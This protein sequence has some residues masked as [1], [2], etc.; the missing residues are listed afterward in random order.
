MSVYTNSIVMFIPNYTHFPNS[1]NQGFFVKEKNMSS[2]EN[3][4]FPC[5]SSNEELEP[6]PNELDLLYQK[7]NS[8]ELIEIGWKCPG[9]HLPSPAPV[10]DTEVK[11]NV[12]AELYARYL[13]YLT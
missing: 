12:N 7:L 2:T 1:Y 13:I 3:W 4:S 8:G 10:A 9:R 11:K 5:L 6:T